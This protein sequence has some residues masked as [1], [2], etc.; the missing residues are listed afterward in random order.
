MLSIMKKNI[1]ASNMFLQNMFKHI[2]GN[3]S[4]GQKKFNKG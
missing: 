2:H 3:A 1:R 4:L